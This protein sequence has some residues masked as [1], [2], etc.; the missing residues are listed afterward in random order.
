MNKKFPECCF[1][2]VCVQLQLGIFIAF[3]ATLM[4]LSYIIPIILIVQEN[5]NDTNAF[6]ILVVGLCA[7]II[8]YV[9]G[10]KSYY[11]LKDFLYHRMHIMYLLQA[12]METNNLEQIDE[13]QL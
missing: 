3:V 1:S 13:I 11:E 5:P 9:L 6:I 10:Y 2:Y 12:E 8:V 4:S 7:M